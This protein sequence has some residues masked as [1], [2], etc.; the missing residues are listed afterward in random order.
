M[1]FPDCYCH[2]HKTD[3][4]YGRD[5]TGYELMVGASQGMISHPGPMFGRSVGRE[6]TISSLFSTAMLRSKFRAR[7]PGVPWGREGRILALKL[8]I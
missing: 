3:G 7:A 4:A 8:G 5:I 1:I 2:S 6:E